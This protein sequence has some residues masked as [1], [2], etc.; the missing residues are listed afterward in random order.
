VQP[1]ERVGASPAT[2]ARVRDRV[3]SLRGQGELGLLADADVG[4]SQ[5]LRQLVE[6]ASAH[7]LGD[8][9]PVSRTISDPGGGGVVDLVDAA[10][11][12]WR[13]PS[14]QSETYRTPS[15]PKSASVGRTFQRNSC[16]STS[17]NEAPAGF[18]AKVR[19][20]LWLLVPPRKSQRKKCLR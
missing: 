1:G 17:S 11:A 4:V 20:P 14:V 13:Q 5:E 6:R 18:M 9:A 15:V 10:L 2:S 8:E 16:E 7:P 3:L 19:M 12:G